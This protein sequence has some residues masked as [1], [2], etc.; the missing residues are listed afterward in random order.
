MSSTVKKT[1]QTNQRQLIYDYALNAS[2]AHP[3]AEQ[4]FQAVRKRLP[5]ISFGTIYRNLDILEKQGLLVPLCYGKEHLRYDAIAENHYHFICTR[6]DKVENVVCEELL[7]LNN[8]IKKR[9]GFKVQF[10][11]MCFYGLCA[12]CR[13]LPVN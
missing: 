11:R 13:Q 10:H 1:R 2:L 6:C 3:T 9:H 5:R 7:E 12:D 8:Q 4:I